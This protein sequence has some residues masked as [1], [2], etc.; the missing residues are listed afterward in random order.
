MFYTSGFAAQE[1]KARG[2]NPDVMLKP[3]ATFAG[4]RRGVDRP[5]D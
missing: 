4:D 3:D 2:G 1:I 5:N